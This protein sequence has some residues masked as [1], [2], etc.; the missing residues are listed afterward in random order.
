MKIM[1]NDTQTLS[2]KFGLTPRK[3]SIGSIVLYRGSHYQVTRLTKKTVNLGYVF[4]RSV[5]H[6]GIPLSEVREDKET[7]YK[8]WEQSDTYKSM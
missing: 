6:K 2:E 1:A 4:S 5:I 7:W 3:V 8:Y